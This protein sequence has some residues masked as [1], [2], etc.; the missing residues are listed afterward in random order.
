MFITFI[1]LV[2]APET[3]QAIDGENSEFTCNLYGG[4]VDNSYT[5]Q[6]SITFQN[7]S[8]SEI[9][10]NSSDFILLPPHNSKLVIVRHDMDTFDQANIS[11]SGALN[12][13]ATAQLFIRRK[14][15]D[16]DS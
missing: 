9:S 10:G 7:Q 6:W 12:L 3:R 4:D 16:L 15:D 13:T 5:R 14:Y 8:T 11:C 1:A 2:I